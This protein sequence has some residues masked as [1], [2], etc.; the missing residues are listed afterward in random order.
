[1][2][3]RCVF[4]AAIQLSSLLSFPQARVVHQ[5]MP[6]DSQAFVSEWKGKSIDGMTSSYD[7]SAWF[8]SYF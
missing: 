2:V 3:P 4:S 6:T 5:T 1:M 8:D 7:C